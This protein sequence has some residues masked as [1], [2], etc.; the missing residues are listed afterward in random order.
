MRTA[1]GT[2]IGNKWRQSSDGRM[3]RLGIWKSVAKRMA[4]QIGGNRRATPEWTPGWTIRKG[5]R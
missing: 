1:R 3:G 5:A 4:C 2:Y